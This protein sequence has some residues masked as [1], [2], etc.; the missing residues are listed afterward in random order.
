MTILSNYTFIVNRPTLK[1]DVEIKK[2]NLQDVTTSLFR[3]Y[4]DPVCKYAWSL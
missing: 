3:I 2:E 4:L 1:S